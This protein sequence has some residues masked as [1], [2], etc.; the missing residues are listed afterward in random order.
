[1]NYG[2]NA[3]VSTQG[4]IHLILLLESGDVPDMVIFYDGVNDI[5]AASQSWMPIVHQ[6][7]SEISNL[8][9]DHPAPIIRSFQNSNS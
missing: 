7:L 8:F 2:E 5:L 3:Y 4:L 9:E 6:N 1:M